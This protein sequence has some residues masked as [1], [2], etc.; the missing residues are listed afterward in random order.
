MP[1]AA[2][3]QKLYVKQFHCACNSELKLNRIR[4][5]ENAQRVVAGFEDLNLPLYPNP[6]LV[7]TMATSMNVYPCIEGRKSRE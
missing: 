6:T 7:S 2:N 4:H 3:P 1:T 5:R